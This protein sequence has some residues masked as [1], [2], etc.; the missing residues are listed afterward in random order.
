MSRPKVIKTDAVD[1]KPYVDYSQIFGGDGGLTVGALG[2]S[3][4]AAARECVSGG[5]RGAVP[6]SHYVPG[7]FDTFYEIERYQYRNTGTNGFGQIL[8]DP[9]STYVLQHGW[10]IAR[11]LCEASYGIQGKIGLTLAVE[12]A[13]NS[14]TNFVAHLEIPWLDFLQIFGSYY[15]RGLTGFSD[16]G[17]LIRTRS[18]SLGRG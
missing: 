10:A 2:R 11:V 18:C 16:F 13:A 14:P 17:R 8:Y 1:I 15:K 5:A 9:K 7:Y 12:A 4:W 3:T 6:G